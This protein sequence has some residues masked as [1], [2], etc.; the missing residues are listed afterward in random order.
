MVGV[1]H[2][3]ATAAPRR[4]H[5][6]HGAGVLLKVWSFCVMSQFGLLQVRSVRSVTSVCQDRALS[7]AAH[8]AAKHDVDAKK[9]RQQPVAIT[10]CR[11]PRGEG[12]TQPVGPGHPA[13]LTEMDSRRFSCTHCMLPASCWRWRACMTCGHSVPQLLQQ[14]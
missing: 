14:V 7:L 8:I 3:T 6:T 10:C 4:R 13:C 5:Q 2:R 11:V 1:A 12:S 9:V